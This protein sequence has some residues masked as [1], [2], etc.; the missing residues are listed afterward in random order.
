MVKA[1]EIGGVLD[2]ILQRLADFMEKGQRL[3][4]RIKGALIYPTVVICI[5]VAIVTGIMYF[6]IPKF[7]EIFNDFNVKLPALTLW[8]VS[9]SKW[10]AGTASPDQRVPGVVWIISSPFIIFFLFKV[11]RKTGFGRAATDWIFLK[12]PVI[13]GLIQKTTV[14]R[15]TRT[16]G[17]LVAAGVPIL[18]AITITKETSGNW[19]FEQALG[20]VHDSIKEGETFAGPLRKAK[21]CDL[22]VVN[23]ID[24]GE[25]TGDLDVMLMKIADNY[26][27]EVDVAV[28]SLLSL[29]EPFMVV[30][31]GGIVG[32]IVLAL[33]LPLVSMIESVSGQKGK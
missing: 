11:I 3:R 17:T 14:A 10:I 33:F 5:A 30:I 4:R 32:T 13:G 12:I 18:E 25:E 24:V 29:L 7:Q 19:V 28:A 27:E 20:K 23:M 2:V 8:L 31:L 26:D 21:V 9:A 6:V 22:I 15:F 16:L 1:G